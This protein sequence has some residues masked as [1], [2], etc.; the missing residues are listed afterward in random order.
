HA[1]FVRN[2]AVAAAISVKEL[3]VQR[4]TQESVKARLVRISGQVRLQNGNSSLRQVQMRATTIKQ[5]EYSNSGD[6]IQVRAVHPRLVAEK[7]RQFFWRDID[8][9]ARPLA[10]RPGRVDGRLQV[11]LWETRSFCHGW[12]PYFGATPPKIANRRGRWKLSEENG[13]RWLLR[14]ATGAPW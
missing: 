5:S 2:L 4:Y 9:V 14:A 3:L 6:A 10:D 8:A 11:I 1:R 13:W 7:H 12:P